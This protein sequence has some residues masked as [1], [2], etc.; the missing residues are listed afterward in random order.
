MIQ[1]R[2][3]RHGKPDLLF[4]GTRLARVDDREISGFSE[5]W[6][7]TALYRTAM[8]QYVLA[9]V[10][11]ITSCGRRSV[12][13]ALVFATAQDLLDYMEVSTRPLSPLAAELLRQAALEDAAFTLCGTF[14]PVALRPP[15]GLAVGAS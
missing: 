8:G 7:E 11:H 4:E 3:Q 10:F 5:N 6:M 9:S 14:A 13:T 12:P 2:L 1:L 15:L